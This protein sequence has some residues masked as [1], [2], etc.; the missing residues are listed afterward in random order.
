MLFR[1]EHPVADRLRVVLDLE[2]R[3]QL[4]DLLRVVAR[5][6]AEIA[7]A[8]EAEELQVLLALH[9][10]AQA[11]DC[12]EVGQVGVALVDRAQL[13]LRLQAGVMEVVLL[14]ELGDEPIGAGTV[15]IELAVAER[16]LAHAA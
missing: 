8:A 10:L 3:L 12:L 9:R 7:L 11:L 2:G 13:E 15:A 14:V 1:S 5:Q 16:S 6:L 4:S